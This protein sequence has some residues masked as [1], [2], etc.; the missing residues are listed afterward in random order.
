MFTNR[1]KQKAGEAD[2]QNL[3]LRQKKGEYRMRAEAAER[4]AAK[5]REEL[6]TLQRRDALHTGIF[7]NIGRF[8]ESLHDINRAFGDLESSLSIETAGAK[9]AAQ[10]S[11]SNRAAFEQLTENLQTMFESIQRSAENV[12]N[13]SESAGKIGG[14]ITL[15]TEIADQT[16]LLA[17]NAA[18]E[19]ARAGEQ[20]RGFA[21]VADE[22]RNLARR[23]GDATE[24]IASLLATI[25]EDTKKA[26]AQLTAGAEDAERFSGES[27]AAKQSMQ[28][29]ISLSHTMENT[30]D[31][32][33]RLS[34]VQLANIEELELK[35][36]VYKVLM[37]ISELQ[38][39]EVPDHTACPL[40]QWYYD[41]EGKDR[42][43]ELAGYREIEAPHRLVHDYVRKT[44]EAFYA[45]DHTAAL[46][47]LEGMETA[48]LEVMRGLQALLQ[49]AS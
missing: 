48:N 18:I 36:E 31:A 12:G 7:P 49:E 11:E 20:G 19:A 46:E 24:E 10:E 39:E 25:R 29:L 1:W 13:L 16:N 32:S 43:S 6:E 26:E 38:P 35:L 34:T 42:L 40:G 37:G 3:R 9:R 22:V 14:I 23:T 5:M 8:S 15:I 33:A 30:V 17:L 27:D 44:L 4:E 21:V 45:G 47:A 28:R 2:A 41:G